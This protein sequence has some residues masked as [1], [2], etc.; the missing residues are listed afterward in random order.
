MVFEHGRV[1]MAQTKVYLA[2]LEA[3]EAS[4]ELCAYFPDQANPHNVISGEVEKK[5]GGRGQANPL[6]RLAG[7]EWVAIGRSAVTAATV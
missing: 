5:R 3:I 6:Y 1:N 2:H 4:G 7:F